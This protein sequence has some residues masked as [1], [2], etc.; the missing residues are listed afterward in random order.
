MEA[1]D[2]MAKRVSEADFNYD[3]CFS[4]DSWDSDTQKC[5]V[6]SPV[7]PRGARGPRDKKNRENIE[8]V[9]RQ[10]LCPHRL[11]VSAGS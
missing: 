5:A 10:W 6:S 7:C 8:G 2:A 1:V 4:S 3:L 9:A 11:D